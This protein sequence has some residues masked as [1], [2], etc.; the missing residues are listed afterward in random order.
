M[1]KVQAQD[2]H[3]ADGAADKQAAIR[4][5]AGQLAEAG[6]VAAGY[7]DGMLRREQ[8][9]STYLGNGIA[10]PHGTTDTRD[11]VQQTGVRVVHFA[12]GVDWGN[13]QVAHVVIGIAAQS[14]EHL[15]ILRQLTHVLGDES[16]APKL[17]ACRDAGELA[18][19]LNGGQ[20]A[21]P[22]LF[23]EETLLLDFPA[24]D[25][26]SLQAAAAGLL[27]N[28]GALETSAL[29]GLIT[30][31]PV[32]LG[33]GLWSLSWAQGV[34]RTAVALVRPAQA[35]SQ[36]GEPVRGLLLFAAKDA[37][38]KP[39]LDCLLALLDKQQQD[40]LW[41]GDAAA[42]VKLLSE[43][44]LDGVAKVFTV[45]NPHGLHARPSA[46]LVKAVKEFNSQIWVSNLDGDGKPVNAKSLMKVV[47]LGVRHGHRLAFTAQGSDAE[48]AISQIGQLIA[49]GLGEGS[50]A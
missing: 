27:H 18:A 26:V 46:V 35:L 48:A 50:A 34:K 13:G 36:D 40:K 1:L 37:Q 17:K 44:A 14:D 5:V 10:I 7:V 22:L 8:Q 3:L 25:R 15:G 21:Q 47:S 6:L 45:T 38:H 33:G 4:L 12:D 42:L 2:I 16:L 31:T 29:A 11:Q 9:T 49:E 20:T 32:H 41:T 19:L 43:P 24:R 30:H 39:V 28:A 23:G